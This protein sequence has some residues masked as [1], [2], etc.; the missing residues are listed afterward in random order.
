MTTHFSK[1]L[2]M[3]MVILPELDG[4]GLSEFRDTSG[5]AAATVPR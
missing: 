3:D 5:I 4:K 2:G 1:G